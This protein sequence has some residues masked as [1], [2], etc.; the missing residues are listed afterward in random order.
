MDRYPPLELL[1]NMQ[2][3]PHFLTAYPTLSPCSMIYAQK[4]GALESAN[5][6]QTFGRLHTAKYQK[7]GQ[8]P[9][10]VRPMGSVCLVITFRVLAQIVPILKLSAAAQIVL[11]AIDGN[12]T[13]LA[14]FEVVAVGTFFDVA[15]LFAFDLI[16]DDLHSVDLQSSNTSLFHDFQHHPCPQ[17]EAILEQETLRHGLELPHTVRIPGE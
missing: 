12:C 10:V 15:T 4:I 17:L 1:Q 13:T 11:A 8:S 2:Q 9:S 7:Q 5:T 14:E 3:L 6:K 16:R